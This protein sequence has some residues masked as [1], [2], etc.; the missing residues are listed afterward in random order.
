M[1]NSLPTSTRDI[2]IASRLPSSEKNVC[3]LT[4]LTQ[5]AVLLQDDI[6]NNA[7]SFDSSASG[8]AESEMV[9][10]HSGDST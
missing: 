3:I 8:D 7:C 9:H 10:V 1:L 4:V 6:E 5:L 2:S